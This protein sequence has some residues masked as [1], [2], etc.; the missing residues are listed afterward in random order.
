[1]V[2]LSDTTEKGGTPC[3]CCRVYGSAI[4]VM[5]ELSSDCSPT[6]TSLQTCFV[7]PRVMGTSKTAVSYRLRLQNRDFAWA[8]LVNLLKCRC[9]AM[10]LNH[11]TLFAFDA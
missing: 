4:H 8:N 9:R 6:T 1:M 2:V 3:D 7:E 10:S 11:R 5:L